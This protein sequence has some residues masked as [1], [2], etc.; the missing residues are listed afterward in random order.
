MG[1][2]L[3][4]ANGV[5]GQVATSNAIDTLIR[6]LG[7]KSPHIEKMWDDGV[8]ADE[9]QLKQIIKDIDGDDY[10]QYFVDLLKGATVSVGFTNG[11][12]VDEAEE[13]VE[14]NE[15]GVRVK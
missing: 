9:A 1:V 4:D 5:V 3:E 13:E 12:A 11:E 8:V 2:Y 14:Y 15:D 10:Y 7:D 6:V